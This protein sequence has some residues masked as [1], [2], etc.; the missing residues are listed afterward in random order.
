MK[1][2]L[3]ADEIS[4][5]KVSKMELP[6]FG[7]SFRSKLK[8]NNAINGNHFIGYSYCYQSLTVSF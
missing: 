3:S 2:K 6:N 4:S 1:R 5:G 7:S 8:T